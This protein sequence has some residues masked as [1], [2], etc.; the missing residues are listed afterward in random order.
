MVCNVYS[1]SVLARCTYSKFTL[2][3]INLA[4]VSTADAGMQKKFKGHT[5]A[6]MDQLLQ[7]QSQNECNNK[8]KS[9]STADGNAREFGFRAIFVL[10]G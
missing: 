6:N 5:P 8:I 7:L 10:Q 4:L 9:D 3:D 1:R 2:E